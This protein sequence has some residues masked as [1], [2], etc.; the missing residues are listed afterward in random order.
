MMAAPAPM[1]DS[2]FGAN[3]PVAGLVQLSGLRRVKPTA[4]KKRMMPILRSTIALFE[5]AD[6]L[7]PYTSR[8]VITM[9]DRNAGMLAMTG[10]P[11]RTGAPVTAEAR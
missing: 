10:R 3:P 6:S 4:M 5:L 7:M 11:K 9:T 1:P 8:T 2:P